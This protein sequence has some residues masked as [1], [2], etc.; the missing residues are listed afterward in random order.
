MLVQVEVIRCEP[1][2]KGRL[3][4]GLRAELA[5]MNICTYNSRVWRRV[6][7]S[8]R[9]VVG[10]CRRSCPDFEITLELAD[11]VV[12][13][14]DLCVVLLEVDLDALDVCFVVFVT[15]TVKFV[16]FSDQ[17]VNCSGCLCGDFLLDLRKQLS[18]GD[19]QRRVRVGLKLLIVGWL[20]SSPV[21][22][23]AA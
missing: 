1:G 12:V 15:L 8:L 3:D 18:N 11:A 16:V 2:G 9:A 5:I 17:C 6:P 21:V 20:L 19:L 10:W 13:G 7:A 14:D 22:V 4:S 23:V